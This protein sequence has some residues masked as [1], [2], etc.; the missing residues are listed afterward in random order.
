MDNIQLWSDVAIDVQT[1]LGEPKPITAITK[2]NPASATSEAHG[3]LPDDVV[4][5]RIVGMRELDYAVVRVG[6][7]TDDG[8]AL[9]GVDAT[10]FATFI[11][12][13]AQ[14]V[15]F[16]ASAAS[17]TEVNAAGGEADKQLIQ[18][19]HTRRGFNIPG[20]ESPLVFTMGSLWLPSDPALVEFKK[21]GKARAIRA[22]RIGFPD[23]AEVLFAGYPTASLAPNGSAGA[24][25]T[26]PV[27]LDVRGLLQPYA[28]A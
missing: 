20:N 23:G 16:G 6:A 5:L 24:P 28:A 11:S 8:F 12:G 26:T 7:V 2:A 25:V 19:I 10:D 3:L 18:T 21:A 4:L 15:T 22:V 9:A 27:S 13:T 14:K 1:V 17:I